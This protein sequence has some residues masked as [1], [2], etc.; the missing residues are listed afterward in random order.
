MAKKLITYKIVNKSGIKVTA[1]HIEVVK[2]H[3]IIVLEGTVGGDAPKDLIRLYNY[4][5]GRKNNPKTWKKYIAKI[6]I[7]QK[8][9]SSNRF[10]KNQSVSIINP[11]RINVL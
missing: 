8:I 7:I 2:S 5:K 3:S 6:L 9:F 10:L 1:K 11:N 4:G